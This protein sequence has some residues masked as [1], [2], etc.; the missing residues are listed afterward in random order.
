MWSAKLSSL[1][2]LERRSTCLVLVL[3]GRVLL[4]FGSFNGAAWAFDPFPA[5]ARQERTVHLST[6]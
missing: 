4:M 6:L 2:S 1:T 5:R 3:G